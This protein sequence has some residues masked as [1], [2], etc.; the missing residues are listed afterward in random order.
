MIPPADDHS[1]LAEEIRTKLRRFSWIAPLVDAQARSVTDSD[2]QAPLG[3]LASRKGKVESSLPR[4]QQ[5]TSVGD[6]SINM[7]TPVIHTNSGIDADDDKYRRRPIHSIFSLCGIKYVPF[8][9]RFPT[10]QLWTA[11]LFSE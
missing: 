4:H 8:C 7:G 2:V 6:V 5:Q 9:V 10:V 1:K 3:A 11:R